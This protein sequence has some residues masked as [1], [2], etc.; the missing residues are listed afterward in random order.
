M[1]TLGSPIHM[2]IHHRRTRSCPQ[3]CG[4]RRTESQSPGSYEPGIG[5]R[6]TPAVI[7]DQLDWKDIFIPVGWFEELA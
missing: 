7:A 2:M 3:E 4:T 1:P 5:P 6:A